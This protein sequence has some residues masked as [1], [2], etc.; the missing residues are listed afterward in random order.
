M[1]NLPF[2]FTQSAS[3]DAETDNDNIGA[4]K[5]LQE[6]LHIAIAQPRLKQRLERL[7]KQLNSDPT[8]TVFTQFAELQD[9]KRSFN[10]RITDLAERA[11]AR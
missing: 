1:N 6:V 3:H 10:Q 4:R 7:E 5:D 8:D 2:S 11:R 9:Q